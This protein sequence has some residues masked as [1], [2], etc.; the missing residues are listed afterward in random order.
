MPLSSDDL[1]AKLEEMKIAATTQS[2]APVLTVEAMMAISR[3][4]EGAHTKNL[5][6]RDA[7]KTYF[8][9][10]MLHDAVL[11]LKSLR[12]LIGARGN[13]SFASAEALSEKLGVISGAVS[14][15]A[16]VNDLQGEVKVCLQDALLQAVLVNVHP[17]TSDRTTSMAPG[18]LVRFLEAIGHAPWSFSL[19]AGD[20]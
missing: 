17:L 13:L 7:K 6:L 15:L 1:L 5:F 10:S 19:A 2:H 20:Q 11:D 9:V 18:D 12:A 4:W 8:L 14:P 3:D 16:A